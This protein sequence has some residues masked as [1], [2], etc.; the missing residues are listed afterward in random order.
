MRL[1]HLTLAT[2]AALAV[3]PA[4]LAQDAG[5]DTTTDTTIATDTGAAAKRVA[6]VGGY[7]LN[8]P[9]RDPGRLAGLETDV[10]GDGAPTLSASWYATDNIAIEAWGT[11][12]FGHRVEL[13]GRKVGSVDT[14]PYALS[15][16][17]HFGAPDR[18]V[19]PF[20]GLGY[21]ELN[22]QDETAQ[23]GGP[24][25]GTRISGETAKGAMATVGLDLNF[26]P[27]WFARTDVRYLHTGE[28]A[29]SVDGAKVGDL[30]LNP[31]IVGVGLGAR[32]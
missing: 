21:Y 30:R 5:T 2:L 12:A 15:A 8:E 7:A 9:K 17:Y 29:V 19:R 4:A 32:F 1:G 24:L 28:N 18:T 14:Q 16:Q 3:A 6:I 27:T 25:D 11:E 13:D 22:V 26:S 23:A 20:V 31:V 10:G